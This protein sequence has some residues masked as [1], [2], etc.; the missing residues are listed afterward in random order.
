M[1]DDPLVT[2]ETD[3]AAMDVP[4][5]WRQARFESVQRRLLAIKY[6][7]VRRLPIS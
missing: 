1:I 7:K 4:A 2:L 6:R 3:K 5:T